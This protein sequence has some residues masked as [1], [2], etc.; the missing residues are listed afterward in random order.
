MDLLIKQ[1]NNLTNIKN[2]NY[3]LDNFGITTK[4][5][6]DLLLLRYYRDNPKFNSDDT[7]TTFCRGTIINK[8]TKKPVF[9]GLKMKVDYDYF[10]NNVLFSDVKIQQY[11]DGTMVNLYYYK[12]KWFTSTK[13]VIDAKHSKWISKQNF[14]SLFNQSCQIDYDKL[15][16]DCCYS[17]VL[18]HKDN[19]IISEVPTNRVVLILTRNVNNNEIV[20]N[21]TDIGKGVIL[22]STINLKNY[23]EL[24]NYIKTLNYNLA[25]VMLYGPNELRTRL[26]CDDYIKASEL[27]GNKNNFL[28]NIID[29]NDTKLNDYL[30]YFNDDYIIVTK[31]KKL[32]NK[33]LHLC[34]NYYFITKIKGDY[35]EIPVHLRK[36]LYNVHL[37]YKKRC[38]TY[39]KKRAKITHSVMKGY[40]HSLKDYVKVH[41]IKNHEKYLKTNKDDNS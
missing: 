32:T 19:R 12:D 25:G 3:F 27:R 15:S 8:K 40:F 22:P 33:L 18:Q 24:E 26:M 30:Y 36:F 14:N 9:V 35:S 20:S 21:P 2:D 13:T 4:Q 17:F 34:F 37:L 39:D 23:S 29:Y 1:I 31:L 5:S 7:M 41:L 16:K 28:L 10:K 6:G 38:E 11:Y